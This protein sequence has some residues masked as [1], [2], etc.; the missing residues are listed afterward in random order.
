LEIIPKLSHNVGKRILGNQNFETFPWV[1]DRVLL[2]LLWDIDF[3]GK[4][5]NFLYDF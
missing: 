4:I 3:S 2:G 5:L 1:N